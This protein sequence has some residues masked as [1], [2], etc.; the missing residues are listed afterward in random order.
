MPGPR[1]IIFHGTGANPGVAWYPWLAGR[2]AA[3][4][5]AVEVPHL[6]GINVGRTRHLL[7]Q[8]P[9]RSVRV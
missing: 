3:R 2:L 5:Y 8:L 4:G 6:P 9:Q 1:A 7:H